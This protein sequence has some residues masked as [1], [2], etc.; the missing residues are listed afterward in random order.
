MSKMRLVLKNEF[1]K[2][3]SRRSYLITLFLL[4]L[5][6][7]VSLVV[8]NAIQKSTGQEAGS[9]IEN[10]FTPSVQSS[11]EGFVDESGLIKTIPK[12]Y[13][14]RLSRFQSEEEAKK[15]LTEQQISA[16]YIISKDFLETGNV[17]YIRP[18]FNPLGSMN[19]S[20]SIDAL[21][22]YALTGGNL[23]LSYRIQNPVNVQQKSLSAEPQRDVTNPLSFF[24]PYVVTFLFYI[25]ILTSSSLMLNSITDEK[26][27]RAME[28]LMTSVTPRELLTGKIIALGLAGLIQTVVWL[29]ASLLMLR[30]SGQN[31]AMA[32]AFQLPASMMLWGILYF[33]LGY[34]IYASLMAAVGALVPNLREAS[35]V[36]TLVFLPMIIP[37]IFISAL[38][39]TPN[40]G[41]TVF[42]SLFPLTSSVS[43]MTRIATVP[44]PI[45]QIAVSL[46]L[47]II[48]AVFLVQAAARLFRAQ[49][50]LSGNTVKAKEFLKMLLSRA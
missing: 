45:W 15:A 42:L 29:G 1:L 12:G 11:M 6:G 25:V 2:V 7:M 21:I 26:Q 34:A 9:I 8:I 32:T 16:Y 49:T 31:L 20:N 13:E 22:D 30:Y 33:I 28:I 47:L 44:V 19:Q 43:M 37:M 14:Y 17:I 27:N 10:I 41:L 50:L 48:T 3:I 39:Q 36:T 4:P 18:D 40:G 23:D 24:I 35:Q 38:I 5:V 46:I